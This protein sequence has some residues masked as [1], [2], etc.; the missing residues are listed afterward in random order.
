M[1]S[2][3]L[4]LTMIGTPKGGGLTRTRYVGLD[5]SGSVKTTVGSVFRADRKPSDVADPG[6]VTTDAETACG[7]DGW[8]LACGASSRGR[9]IRPGRSS[10]VMMAREENEPLPAISTFDPTLLLRYGRQRLVSAPR[11]HPRRSSPA[12]P[13]HRTQ[14]RPDCRVAS[15]ISGATAA[16]RTST[17]APRT[18]S[19]IRWTPRAPGAPLDGAAA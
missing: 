1:S 12:L 3:A 7:G 19:R 14:V 6:T 9:T 2:L 15:P 16:N 18:T 17:R 11:A 5:V 13:S 8:L 4:E 10:R